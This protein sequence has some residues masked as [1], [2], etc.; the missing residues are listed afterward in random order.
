[1][2][3]KTAISIA[4]LA[5]LAI[6]PAMAGEDAPCVE[7][8]LKGGYEMAIPCPDGLDEVLS[9]FQP[10]RQPRNNRRSVIEPDWPYD[11]GMVRRPPAP[12]DDWMLRK[13]NRQ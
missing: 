11:D 8:R 13:P 1:M 2:T 4:F 3:G 9:L 7:L 10:R 12:D 6:N 5:V